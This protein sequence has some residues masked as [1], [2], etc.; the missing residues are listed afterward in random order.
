MTQFKLRLS[1]I[2]KQSTTDIL[3]QG[4]RGKFYLNINPTLNMPF[5]L[6]NVNVK[7]YRIYMTKLRTSSHILRVESGR[8]KKPVKEPFNERI[9]TECNVIDDEFHFMFK[10]KL[11]IMC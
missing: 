7:K 6:N 9:C 10:C 1:D 2:L 8:W 4:T 5:Y 3:R 11:H